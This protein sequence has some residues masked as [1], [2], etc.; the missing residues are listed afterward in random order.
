MADYVFKPM[1]RDD[2]NKLAL[3]IAEK[4]SKGSTDKCYFHCDDHGKI[5]E[6]VMIGK[7]RVEVLGYEI[8]NDTG[9]FGES[10]P[11]KIKITGYMERGNDKEFV[12]PFDQAI[13]R[14]MFNGPCT[15]VFWDD[16]TKTIVKLS[17]GDKSDRK[18]AL[19][20]AIAK[21]KYGTMSRVHREVDQFAKSN[22]QRIAILSYIVAQE[23]FDVDKLLN[24][25]KIRYNGNA[26]EIWYTE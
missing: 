21:K 14:I 16:D 12:P 15:I 7:T 18:V 3:C 13:T 23:G 17:E 20:Y 6:H 5:L 9:F 2:Y 8:E 1:N 26:T 24:S 10:M 19:I 4:R 11:P 22:A 25:G